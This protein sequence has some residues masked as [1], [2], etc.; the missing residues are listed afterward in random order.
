MS[1]DGLT[2]AEKIRTLQ[3]A[4][5]RSAPRPGVPVPGQVEGRDDDGH[6]VRATHDELGHTVV[7]RAGDRQ[8]VV[9]RPEPIRV[10]FTQT[11]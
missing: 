5:T 2:F 3:F 4:P 10:H 6:R 7:E 9:V 8:D 11:G 1:D